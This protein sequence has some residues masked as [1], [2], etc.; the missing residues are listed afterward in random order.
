MALLEAHDTAEADVPSDARLLQNLNDY[1]SIAFALIWQRQAIYLAA[2]VLTAFYVDP[3]HALVFYFV[4]VLCELQDVILARRVKALKPHQYREIYTNYYWI[5][6][7]TVLSS[8]AICLYAVSVAWK[9][10]AGGHFAP[11]FFL[12]AAALF[13]AMNNHQLV[14]ALAIRLAMY[15]ISFL[16]IVCTDLWLVRPSLDSY[17]WLH[18]F[19]VIFVM[20]FLIDCSVVFLKLY[21]KNLAQLE[22]LRQEHERT[23]A[24]Y[25][26]KSQFVSTVSHELRTPL[27]SIKGTLDLVNC[28]ALGE[29]PEKASKLLESA[30]KNSERLACLIDDVLD[31]QRIEANEMQYRKEILSVQDL[32]EDAVNGNQGYASKHNVSLVQDENSDKSLKIQGDHKRLMQ[33]MAN[34]ISN[35]VKFSPD[36]SRVTVGYERVDAVIRIHVRDRGCGIPDGSEDKIFERFSQLDSSD[37]RKA[38]GSGLGMNISRDIATHHDGRI[39]YES[40]VDEGTTFYLELPDATE[41]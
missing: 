27:T 13:A 31:L 6:L 14:L 34:M 28:G 29:L 35:A 41:S 16:V 24:A 3:T 8:A 15:G 4:I 36:G 33:I 10:E 11:L 22:A 19:T 9:Q 21:R 18:F 30:G 25:V 1:T 40:V 37:Q 20:Y 7:N 26:A 17:I 12:F 32:V 2:A 23:K 5:L 38:P 39:F